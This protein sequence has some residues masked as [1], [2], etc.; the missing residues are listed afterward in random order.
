M[1]KWSSVLLLVFLFSIGSVSASWA[2]VINFDDIDTSGG[3]LVQFPQN[4]GTTHDGFN[5][6]TVGTY[7]TYTGWFAES[8]DW[9]NYSMLDSLPAL[10]GPNH[11]IN[12]G[13]GY[14]DIYR[15]TPFLFDGV[16]LS[17]DLYQN[18]PTWGTPSYV[19]LYGYRNGNLVGSYQAILVPEV[20]QYFSPGWDFEIDALNFLPNNMASF[21]GAFLVDDFTYRIPQT[22]PGPV[23]PEPVSLSL[24]GLG[25]IG[26]VVRKRLK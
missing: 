7:D 16:Y 19:M 25:C 2:N 23:I 6:H 5:S 17:P 20:M 3:G 4:F 9:Y 21:G 18:A 1:K 11:G 14:L 15:T 8:Y 24:L 12:G 26:F 10:S 13:A 22:D